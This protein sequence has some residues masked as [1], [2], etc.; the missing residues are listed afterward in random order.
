MDGHIIS[1]LVEWLVSGWLVAVTTAEPLIKSRHAGDIA[2]YDEKR[3]YTAE[4]VTGSLAGEG[5]RWTQCR[6]SRASRQRRNPIR[7]IVGARRR[8]RP[9]TAVVRRSE[10]P[11]KLVVARWRRRRALTSSLNYNTSNDGRRRRPR[12]RCAHVRS[13]FITR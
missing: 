6:R 10:Y 2:C 3:V 7:R 13:T 12:R 5:R 8:L 11:S 4:L 9:I 1:R